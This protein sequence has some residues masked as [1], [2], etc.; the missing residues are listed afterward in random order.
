[1]EQ[2][3][4][5]LVFIL[6]YGISYGVVLFTIS[7]GLVVMMG[8]MRVVNLAHG[9]F[10]AI[11]GY[12]AVS[13]WTDFSVP[14]GLAIVIAVAAV[15]VASPLIERLFF[16]PLYGASELDQV[17]MTIGLTFVAVA[18]LNLF[19]GSTVLAVRMPA[20]LGSIIDL[21]GHPIQLYRLFVVAL[22]IVLLFALW[23]LFDATSFGAR[24]RAA[25]DNRTM[26]QAI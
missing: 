10:A 6:L 19:F 24:L 23:L 13:L 22:G 25:V 8:L 11:G 9:A 3:L 17:L 12:I 1:M 26:A 15:V 5:I 16:V 14:F 18:G 7:V 21:G 4:S 20:Q 2:L